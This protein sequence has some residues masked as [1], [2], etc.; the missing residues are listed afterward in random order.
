MCDNSAKNNVAVYVQVNYVC[1]YD[2]ILEPV[3]V[4]LKAGL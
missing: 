3:D 2:C 4:W 1:L